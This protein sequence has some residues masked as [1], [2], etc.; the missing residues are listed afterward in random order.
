MILIAKVALP[1]ELCKAS[2]SESLDHTSPYTMTRSSHQK[3]K[4]NRYINLNVLYS[5]IN[6]LSNYKVRPQQHSISAYTMQI[7]FSLDEKKITLNPHVIVTRQILLLFERK[8][9]IQ[10]EINTSKIMSLKTTNS[11]QW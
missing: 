5:V 1:G 2:L 11:A 6:N 8:N 3:L 10:G 7:V 9:I 4:A